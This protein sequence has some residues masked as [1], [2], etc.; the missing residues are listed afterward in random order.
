[1]RDEPWGQL[2]P[3]V[4]NQIEEITGAR[5]WVRVWIDIHLGSLGVS[6]QIVGQIKEQLNGG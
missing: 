4:V 3:V 2:R 5:V 6:R 1:M